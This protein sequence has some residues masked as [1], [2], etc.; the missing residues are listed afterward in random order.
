[1][2]SFPYSILNWQRVLSTTKLVRSFGV[3]V[4]PMRYKKCAVL[5]LVVLMLLLSVSPATANLKDGHEFSIQ[6]GHSKASAREAFDLH[7]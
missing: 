6:I 1:M 7:I 2:Q 5:A 3:G 4:H